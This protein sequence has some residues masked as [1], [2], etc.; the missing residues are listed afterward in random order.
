MQLRPRRRME[1]GKPLARVESH[2]SVADLTVETLDENAG[3]AATAA[4]I[5]S[6]VAERRFQRRQRQRARREQWDELKNGGSDGKPLSSRLVTFASMPLG[7]DCECTK[8]RGFRCGLRFNEAACSIFDPCHNEFFNCVTD[9][10]PA[11]AFAALP[12]VLSLTQHPS[13]ASAPPAIRAALVATAWGTATQ[14]VASLAAPAVG[15]EDMPSEPRWTKSRIEK[16]D[17]NGLMHH[18]I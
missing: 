5:C 4:A 16:G 18:T 17:E 7:Y 10:V 14:H 15:E 12:A 2:T 8:A 13:F 6:R 9:L 11:I 3:D 1:G